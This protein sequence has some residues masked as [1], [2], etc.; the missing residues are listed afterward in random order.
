MAAMLESDN[1]VGEWLDNFFSAL[2][3]VFGQLSKAVNPSMIY[4]K[5]DLIGVV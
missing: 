3:F 5:L 1:W 4:V 2:F